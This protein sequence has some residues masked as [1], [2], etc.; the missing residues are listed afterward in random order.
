MKMIFD[1]PADTAVADNFE[2]RWKGHR[3][4]SFERN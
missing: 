3:F 1:S 4:S 2:T